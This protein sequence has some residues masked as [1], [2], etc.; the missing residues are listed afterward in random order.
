M[1]DNIPEQIKQ[2]RLSEI[3]D[4]QFRHSFE[5]LSKYKNKTTEVL[6]EKESKKSNSFW[7]GRNEQNIMVVMPKQDYIPGDFVEVSIND[8]TST[9]LIGNIK[10]KIK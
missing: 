6:I 7:S 5:N 9:T 10:K 1:K 3:I 4:L 2:R 8:N